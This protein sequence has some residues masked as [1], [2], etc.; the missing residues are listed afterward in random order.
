MVL[1]RLHI[2]FENNKENNIL[3]GICNFSFTKISS[4]EQLISVNNHHE[5]T[6]HNH[7][8]DYHVLKP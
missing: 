1:K 8:L 5:K 3:T 6:S 7:A 2:D 4:W